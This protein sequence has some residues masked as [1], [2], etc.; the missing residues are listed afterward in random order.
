MYTDSSF[1]SGS[2]RFHGSAR[3]SGG[4][5]AIIWRSSKQQMVTLSTAE[6]EPVE[7]IEGTTLVSSTLGPMQEVTGYDKG[8]AAI[9]LLA[10]SSG[11]W[12]T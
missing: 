3:V 9:S 12:Q 5:S 4:S 1:A 11:S 7:S 8:K 6:P 2:G 10:R